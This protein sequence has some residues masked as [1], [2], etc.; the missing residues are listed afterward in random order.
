MRITI[1]VAVA[2]DPEAHR[3]LDRIVTRIEDGWHV[4][5]TTE[6]DD[7]DTMTST[8]WFRDAGRQRRHLQELLRRSIRLGA[9]SFAPHGRRV[10]IT[11]EPSRADEFT[12][13]AARRLVEVP[14]VVLVEDGT[15]DGAFLDRIVSELDPPLHKIWGTEVSPVRLDHA[16]GADQMPREVERRTKGRP[17]DTRLVVVRDSDKT[18]PD[19]EESGAVKRLRRTCQQR[20]V[21]C[22][23]LAKREAENY[24]PRGLLDARPNAG[25]EHARRVAAWDRLDEDQ[26]DHFDMKNG[27][28]SDLSSPERALFAGVSKH[29]RA[30]LERGFGDKLH[31]CWSVWSV[32]P[33]HELRRRSRGDLERC[34][35]LIRSQV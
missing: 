13:E 9:W 18:V 5:D 25:P 12:P 10:R 17:E 3:W 15:S 2:N 20:G 1:T 16:G 23:V 6:L 28:G 24:L 19:A 21:A 32:H 22:W 35:A 11:G 8:S 14:L 29:D 4:W 27:L 30:I 34:L 31:D 26:K 7:T 33:R